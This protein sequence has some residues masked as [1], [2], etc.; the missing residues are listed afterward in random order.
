MCTGLY[1][2]TLE[3]N[4]SGVFK[5]TLNCLHL[6]RTRTRGKQTDKS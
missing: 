6:V 5:K 4:K 1:Y 3:V 2:I